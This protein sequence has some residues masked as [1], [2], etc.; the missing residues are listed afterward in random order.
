MAYTKEFVGDLIDG[1]LGWERTKSIISGYKDEDRFEKYLE[2][3][4]GRVP[5]DDKILL[6]LTDE[7]FIVEKGSNLLGLDRRALS[8]GY[9][10]YFVSNPQQGYSRPEFDSHGRS[11]IDTSLLSLGFCY[12]PVSPLHSAGSPKPT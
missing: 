12:P 7:L 1:K 10:F 3:L 8:E 6:P 4:S 2:A 5:W 11:R 9:N